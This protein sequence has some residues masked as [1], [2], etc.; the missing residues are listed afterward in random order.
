[1]PEHTS[2]EFL[3]CS[4]VLIWRQGRDLHLRAPGGIYI[5]APRKTTNPRRTVQQ[6][7]A[8]GV[9]QPAAHR[10]TVNCR[11][12]LP[13]PHRTTVC[14]RSPGSQPMQE[15]IMQRHRDTALSSRSPSL[16]QESITAQLPPPAHR[17]TVYCRRGLCLQ[18]FVTAQHTTRLLEPPQLLHRLYWQPLRRAGP[19]SN[20]SMSSMQMSNFA[21][22]VKVA[23]ACTC[24]R[25]KEKKKNRNALEPKC[26]R[27]L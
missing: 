20:F 9:C 15:S 25:N 27:M 7:I 22:G 19:F 1:M 6:F 21:K 5:S 14:W 24:R 17:T 8:E 13:A 2:I 3:N 23:I 16:L 11:R 12:G 4:S 18:E 26:L 10:T